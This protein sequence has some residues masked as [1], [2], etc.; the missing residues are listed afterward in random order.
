MAEPRLISDYWDPLFLL[1]GFILNCIPHWA[2]S[3]HPVTLLSICF[4]TEAHDSLFSKG[5]VIGKE[6]IQLFARSMTVTWCS[7]DSLEP[8]I[9]RTVR[10]FS[11]PLMDWRFGRMVMAPSATLS[12]CSTGEIFDPQLSDPTHKKWPILFSFSAACRSRLKWD[13]KQN[14]QKDLGSYCWTKIAIGCF[15]FASF[16]FALFVPEGWPQGKFSL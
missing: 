11:I 14:E 12:W 4:W 2:G 13:H 7:S 9:R 8:T 3:I 5:T 15:K 16:L 6:V 10:S 1:I